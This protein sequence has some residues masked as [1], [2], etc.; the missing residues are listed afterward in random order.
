[1]F[2]LFSCVSCFVLFFNVPIQE[3]MFSWQLFMQ[4]SRVPL[5][6]L[7]AHFYCITLELSLQAHTALHVTYGEMITNYCA[8]CQENLS[9][10]HTNTQKRAHTHG[11][12]TRCTSMCVTPKSLQEAGERFC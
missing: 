6:F 4:S 10:T 5:L 12:V 9:I 1:M 3:N 7:S 8:S 11:R 2:Y